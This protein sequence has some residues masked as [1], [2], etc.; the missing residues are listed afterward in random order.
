[1]LQCIWAVE[2][3]FK[4]T[5]KNSQGISLK[6][7]NVQ[8]C[9]NT[10]FTNWVGEVPYFERN[11]SEIQEYKYYS[12]QNFAWNSLLHKRLVGCFLRTKYIFTASVYV[13][14][15][16]MQGVVS[17]GSVHACVYDLASVFGIIEIV[18]IYILY[19]S[20]LRRFLHIDVGSVKVSN[21]NTEC[22]DGPSINM[23][24]TLVF[25]S[26]RPLKISGFSFR[27][28]MRWFMAVDC[29]SL[30]THCRSSKSD[31]WL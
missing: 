15:P 11:V 4:V 23:S 30:I 26:I 25:I 13:L 17:T 1:M 20:L 21:I 14:F 3:L 19:L 22:K 12:T 5:I 6:K 9:R 24:H 31:K 27:V 28:K 29:D 16:N 8:H 7:Q 10:T 2:R 18:F